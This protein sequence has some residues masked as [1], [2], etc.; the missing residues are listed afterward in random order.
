MP[1]ASPDFIW[2]R[3]DW[4]RWSWNGASL[5]SLLSAIHA[6]RTA[7]GA[8]LSALDDD[9]RGAIV[10]ELM[11]RETVSTSAIEGVKVDAA[12]ARSSIMR[13]LKLGVAPGREWQVTPQTIGLIDLLAD[14]AA[15]RSPLTHARLKDWHQALFPTGKSGL[16]LVLA[17]E[18]RASTEPMRVI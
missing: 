13:R 17:G 6:Q 1:I 14:C 16:M 18:Y 15:D 4:P 5:Q 12:A 11:T 2:Q 9:H 8:R 10:A 3:P 7:L